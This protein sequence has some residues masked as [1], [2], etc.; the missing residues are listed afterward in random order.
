MSEFMHLT[1]LKYQYG[2]EEHSWDLPATL[3]RLMPLHHPCAWLGSVQF[4]QYNISG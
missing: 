4:I 1:G 3:D 2:K